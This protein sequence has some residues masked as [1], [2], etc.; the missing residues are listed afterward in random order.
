VG[1][2]FDRAEARDTRR[3]GLLGRLDRGAPVWVAERDGVVIGL[4]EC[5]WI[6]VTS[7]MPAGT[8]LTAGRWAHVL[9]VAVDPAHRGRG[10][11]RQLIATAHA[12]FARAGVPSYLY[13]HPANP[14]S[15]VF[16]PR[17]GYRP[18]WTTWEYRRAW[19]RRS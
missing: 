3:A 9:S 2:A 10:V 17:Q 7:K 15:S 19:G 8:R 5:E 1:G 6:D 14:L 13:Y 18:V 12:E 4:I 16:W 11:G